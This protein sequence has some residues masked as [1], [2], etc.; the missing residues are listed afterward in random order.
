MAENDGLSVALVLVVEYG[1][2]L[3]CKSHSPL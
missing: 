3:E 2:G 1:A